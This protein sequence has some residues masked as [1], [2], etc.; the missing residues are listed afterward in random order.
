M[1]LSLRKELNADVLVGNLY[2]NPSLWGLSS[3]VDRLR[4]GQVV[5]EKKETEPIHVK[6]LDELLEDLGRKVPDGGSRCSQP[7]KRCHLLPYWCHKL[8]RGVPSQG[9]LGEGEH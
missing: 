7:V 1:S 4:S 2:H 5:E 9:C 6:S 3:Q 8:L